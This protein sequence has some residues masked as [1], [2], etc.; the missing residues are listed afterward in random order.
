MGV[1]PLSVLGS[2]ALLA[3]VAPADVDDALAALKEEGI[4]AA[5]VGVAEEGSGVSLDGELQPTPVRD[6]M[7][8]LWD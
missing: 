8:D 1:D 6:E 3:A 2:G 4:E 7:Y 5:E